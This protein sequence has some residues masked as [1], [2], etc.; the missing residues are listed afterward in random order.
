MYYGVYK[1]Q[2]KINESWQDYKSSDNL[3]ELLNLE[4]T[5]VF[6]TRIISFNPSL[7]VKNKGCCA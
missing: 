1:I 3:P 5:L 7:K 6:E 2:I 4:K